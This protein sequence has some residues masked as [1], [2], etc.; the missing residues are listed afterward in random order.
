MK[1]AVACFLL[2]YAC[3]AAMCFFSD[4]PSRSVPLIIV[5]ACAAL[6]LFAATFA[7]AMSSHE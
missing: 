6:L 1:K 3:L 7:S 2:A 5:F 4:G